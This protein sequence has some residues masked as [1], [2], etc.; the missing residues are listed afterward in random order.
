METKFLAVKT[1][2][3]GDQVSL[4]FFVSLGVSFWLVN[5]L[6]KFGFMYFVALA[7]SFIISFLLFN[8]DR[9]T[10]YRK[11]IYQ[12]RNQRLTPSFKDTYYTGDEFYK[13][14][15]LK[16]VVILEDAETSKKSSVEELDS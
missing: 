9:M 1:A 14:P 11:A 4:G 12:F 5:W 16:D 15:S 6:I 10:S 7:A 2:N 3:R 8:G 13:V